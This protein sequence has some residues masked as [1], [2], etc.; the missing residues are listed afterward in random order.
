MDGWTCS[1]DEEEDIFKMEFDSGA[2]AAAA[3]GGGGTVCRTQRRASKGRPRADVGRCRP[4]RDEDDN[5]G[6]A[7]ATD[8]VTP[9]S[10]SFVPPHQLVEHGC[11]SL[12]LRDELKRKP[13][14]YC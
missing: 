3:A 8:V 12:G 1:E 9:L 14:V 11:F 7:D 5:D 4:R 13:G 10:A 6:R 2:T